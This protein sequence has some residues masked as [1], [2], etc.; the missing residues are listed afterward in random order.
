MCI[1]IYR[2]RE[3]YISLSYTITYSILP[4]RQDSRNADTSVYYNVTL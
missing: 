1:Y 2:E 3:V 4:P